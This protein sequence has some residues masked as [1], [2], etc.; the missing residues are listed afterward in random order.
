[1]K[2]RSLLAITTLGVL[3]AACA[4]FAFPLT[5]SAA[6]PS[7]WVG[8]YVPGAPLFIAPL[9]ALESQAGA[10]AKV[11][12][13]FQNTSQ[14]FT[15]A[16][17]G[18]AVSHGTTPLI[19]LEFWN[20]ANGLNQPSFS[21]RSI[22]G[23]VHDAYLHQYAR[24]AK[25]FGSEVW[26]RPLHEMNGNWYPWGGTVNGNTPADFVPAWRHIKDIFTAEGA[27][28]VKF[29]WAPNSDGTP[30]GSPNAISSYFPGDAYVDYLALDGYNF[31]TGAG[32]TWRTFAQV[33]DP[34]YAAVTALS[35]KP[36]F[37]AET[38]C[39]P[40]GGDKPAWIA[41]MFASIP[42]RYPRI[43]GVTWF[44]ANKEHD[45]RLECS[46]AC[47]AAFSSG[48]ANLN[49]APADPSAVPVYRFYN[50]RT[51]THFYTADP[52]EKAY[53]QAVLAATYR[54]DGVAYTVNTTNP[55]NDTPL[56]RFYNV[57]TGTHFY[58]ADTSEKNRI[59][60]TMASTY[61]LDGPAYNVSAAAPSGSTPVYRFYNMSTGTHFYTADPVEK[62]T[63]LS[64]GGAFAF[65]GPAFYLAH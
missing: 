61:R 33:F 41:D 64:A 32:S 2:T 11:S 1:M 56:W 24:D 43:V 34:G 47:A 60:S 46:P 30:A 39:S 4:A 22:S 18:N 63:L 53:L 37:I 55:V 29:V 54:L 6:T 38:A 21:L 3:L 65:D 5:A 7:R 12:N 45:W 20:P 58:T 49:P 23:G 62:S 51:G 48:V 52:A 10:T 42:T 36:L 19:T 59:Q 26:L 44:N 50:M 15:A 9:S 16:Q 28:N 31:G 35:A 27:T 40:V 57:R 14:G 17:A 25:A 8:F 13:Y